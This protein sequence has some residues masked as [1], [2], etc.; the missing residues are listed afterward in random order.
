MGF[1]GVADLFEQGSRLTR[2]LE[3]AQPLS[4][5]DWTRTLL[6]TEIVFASDVLGSGIDWQS[7]VGWS[8]EE[9]ITVLRELQLKLMR[10]G[11]ISVNSLTLDE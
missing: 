4:R 6:A 2:A 9:T 5:R 8:D 11:A 10:A 1:S 3:A 7:T